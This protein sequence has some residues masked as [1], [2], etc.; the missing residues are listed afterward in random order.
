VDFLLRSWAHVQK[1]TSFVAIEERDGEATAEGM[2]L[3]DVNEKLVAHK[4]D[5]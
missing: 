1:Y 4:A 2:Q 3:V 5:R